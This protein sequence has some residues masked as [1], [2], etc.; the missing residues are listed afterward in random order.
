MAGELQIDTILLPD[1]G[2]RF[3]E[4]YIDFEVKDRTIDRTLVSDFVAIKRIFTVAWDNPISGTLLAD[5]V[6]LYMA[7]EDVTFTV[8]NADTTNT[9]YTCRLDIGNEYLREIASG[10]YAFSGLV[11]TLEEV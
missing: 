8:T 10:N 7:K 11:I 2:L 3:S 1:Y 5:L 6:D 9:V 4:G